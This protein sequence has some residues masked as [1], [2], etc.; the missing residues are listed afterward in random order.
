[1]IDKLIKILVAIKLERAR[2]KA[3][4][5]DKRRMDLREQRAALTKEIDSSLVKQG[6][7]ACDVVAAKALADQLGIK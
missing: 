3:D 1:M 6:E 2:I 5:E 7:L 4:K